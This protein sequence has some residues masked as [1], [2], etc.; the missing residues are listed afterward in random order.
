MWVL[1]VM[2]IFFNTCVFGADLC[3]L[4]STLRCEEV[5]SAWKNSYFSFAPL[6][7]PLYFCLT[8]QHHSIRMPLV[9]WSALM[10]ELSTTSFGT[11][12]SFFSEIVNCVHSIMGDCVVWKYQRNQSTGFIRKPDHGSV[13]RTLQNSNLQ[14]FKK[15]YAT[16]AIQTISLWGLCLQIVK[17]QYIIK[18][19][20]WR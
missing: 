12:V 11:K 17:F 14:R 15:A 7:L 1:F 2:N 20:A 19:A 9:S 8:E 18:S 3:D 16:S 5:R 13:S 10:W 6:V 4:Q